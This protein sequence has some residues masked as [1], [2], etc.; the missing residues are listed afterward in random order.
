MLSAGGLRGQ[1]PSGVEADPNDVLVKA[2]RWQIKRSEV[3]EIYKRYETE[4]LN[5]GRMVPPGDKTPRFLYLLDN[6]VFNRCITNI[7]FP[8]DRELAQREVDRFVG[9]LKRTLGGDNGFLR[10]IRRAGFEERMFRELKFEEALIVQ[11][12]NRHLR[13]KITIPDSEVR[14]YYDDNRSNFD[15]PELFRIAHILVSTRDNA[16]GEPMSDEQKKERRRVADELLAKAKAGADFG[17]LARQKSEDFQTRESGGEMAFVRG[18]VVIELEAAA[19]ALMP[20]QIGDVVET[21]HGFHI[22]RLL[23]HRR[24]GVTSFESAKGD[25]RDLLVQREVEKQ[26][27]DWYDGLRA[28]QKVEYTALAPKRTGGGNQAP[29]AGAVPAKP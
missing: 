13:S 7:A 4:M 27:P 2:S 6:M 25:I 18:Q 1:G 15:Q 12:V 14:K 16:T 8:E 3:D 10:Q 28:A 22:V 9:E 29:A 11:S 17:A 5:Q 23:E 21:H 20:G 19:A 26:I 24:A